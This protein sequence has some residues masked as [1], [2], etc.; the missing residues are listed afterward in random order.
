ML[1]KF[2][3]YLRFFGWFHLEFLADKKNL[4]WIVALANFAGYNLWS[5]PVPFM[6]G[7]A[8]RI[9]DEY[10]GLI[11]DK[12][13]VLLTFYGIG[14]KICMLIM[15]DVHFD[16][17]AG[18]VN[19]SHFWDASRNLV[20]TKETSVNNIARE[21]EAWLPKNW[22]RPIN[23]LFAGLRQL[24]SVQANRE[25]IT[26]V[27]QRLGIWKQVEAIVVVRKDRHRKTVIE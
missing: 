16:Y 14:R 11:P 9:Q 2:T 6:V 13:I 3:Y 18:I 26:E 15:Q 21:M 5:G 25:A 24:W 1:F 23:P 10:H 27:Y 8:Y 4:D 12:P 19:D 17:E 22:W 7:A 20:W